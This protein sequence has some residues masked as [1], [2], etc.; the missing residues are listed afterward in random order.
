ML[1]F[2]VILKIRKSAIESMKKD[3]DDNDIKSFWKK[4]VFIS[5]FHFLPFLIILLVWS[6]N[7]KLSSIETYVGTGIAIFTGLFFSLLLTIGAKV[8]S[9][10]E[11]PNKDADNFNRFKT[12]MKQIANIVL[13]VIVI[14]IVIFI[15]MLT[16]TI[17]RTD[18]C[19]Y[20]E[21]IFTSMAMFLLVRFFISLFFIIQR[22]HFLIKDEINNIL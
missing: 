2:K 19:A 22:F 17:F 7:I 9:E 8:R 13:Y 15:I 10:N 11:N 12:N 3:S 14:R 4:F 16:N 1:D 21:K 6:K 20:I 18:S 5:T